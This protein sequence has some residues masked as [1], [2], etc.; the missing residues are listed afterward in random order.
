MPDSATLELGP[1]A[2]FHDLGHDIED[3][4]KVVLEGLSR[5]RK[6]IPAKYFY[7]AAGSR[8]FDRICKLAEYYPTRTEI[9]LLTEHSKEIAELAGPQASLIEFGSGSSV[10]VRILLDA[11]DRP[12]AYLPIDISRDHLI[13]ASRKLAADYPGIAVMPI[14]ADYTRDFVLPGGTTRPRRFGF[15]PGS[16][17]GNFTPAEAEAF[18]RRSRALLG[19]DG[20]L[21]IG[22]DLVKDEAI[23]H[24]AY[25]DA[26]GVTAAFNRN[27]LVRINR[28]LGAAIDP[29]AFAHQAPYNAERACIEMHLISRRPQ[30]LEIGGASIRFE[31]G[32]SIHTE[33]SHKFTVEGFQ[34]HARNAG[35]DPVRAWVD[36][37]ELFSVHYLAPN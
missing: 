11:L 37:D 18:L 5:E 7:D 28:E 29:A 23:L 24:A 12:A 36:R 31:A 22:V 19:S 33:D 34:G 26:E 10:K 8:L 17:I 25:N 14:C 6:Q 27:L 9:A 20:G 13:G 3:F 15:F 4:R 2:G 32:E 16:T 21:L 30:T 1:L 35:W